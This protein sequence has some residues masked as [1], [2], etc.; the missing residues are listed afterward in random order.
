MNSLF[1]AVLCCLSALVCEVRGTYRLYGYDRPRHAARP[2][3]RPHLHP[4]LHP[5]HNTLNSRVHGNNYRFYGYHYYHQPPRI[6]PPVIH[7]QLTTPPPTTPPPTEQ[8]VSTQRSII[9][10]VSADAAGSDQ[11]KSRPLDLVFIIDS[12]RSVRPGEFEKVKVFLSDLVDTLDIGPDGTRV[13][14]VNYASTVK[15][16]F[17]LKTYMTS[18]ELK[19]ALARIEPLSSGTMTGQAIR[20]TIDEAFTQGIRGPAAQP[21]HYQGGHNCDGRAA[22][23]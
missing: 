12:S 8:P 5:L 21:Q 2:V 7:P 6:S 23:G 20:T 9:L 11:C 18:I 22:A 4:N 15:I 16:E 14:V 10:T 17:Q 19:R 1:G 3:P 13:A